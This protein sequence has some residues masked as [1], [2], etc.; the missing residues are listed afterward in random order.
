[1]EI[2]IRRATADDAGTLTSIAFASKAV[3]GYDE[4]F[5][6]QCRKEL[7]ITTRYIQSCEVY[8][9]MLRE[10]IVGFYGMTVAAPDGVL[11]YLFVSPNLLKK[12]IG[13]RLWD[14]LLQIAR[15]RQVKTISIAAD[16]NAEYFYR[17]L[18]A[19]R[20]G[21]IP[22]GSIPG[23]FIPLLTFIT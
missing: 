5:M 2:T 19:K 11:D 23:R 21:E 3:W 17:A 8:A 1:M 15:A 10:Q 4:L 18:G 6:E 9:A 16:P 12:G 13:R 14:H 7:T 22:S 20:V